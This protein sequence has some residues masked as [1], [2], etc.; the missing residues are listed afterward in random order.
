MFCAG[1]IA[2]HRALSSFATAENDAP[3]RYGSRVRALVT[4]GG[5]GIGANIA[6]KLA[7]DGWEVVVAARTREQVEAVAEETG[8]RAVALDVTD[9]EAVERVVADAEPVELLVANAGIGNQDGSTWEM[10][11]EDWWRVLEVNVLGVHLCCRAV[12]P[13]MLER[14]SGRI[15]ITG[16]GAAYLPGQDHTAY[17][18]SK[19]AVCRYGETLAGELAGRIPVFFFSPGL[20]RTEMTSSGSDDLPWT[21]PELA[22]Q[23]VAALATGRYDALAGRYLH[24]EHD[25]LDDLLSRIDA[26]REQDLNA[27][28]LRR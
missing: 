22:P 21:P 12:I 23:L 17:P 6:R 1:R 9:R 27:I 19:A 13:G 25:D 26:V 10:A 3:S 24:A 16:S 5:R 7:E 18:A 15:V 20:V 11:P 28:R 14:G 8:G 2:H 4:G